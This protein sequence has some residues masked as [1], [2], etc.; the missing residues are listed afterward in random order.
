MPGPAGRVGGFVQNLT[1]S[2]T[3]SAVGLNTQTP[4]G[5]QFTTARSPGSATLNFSG[6]LANGVITGTLTFSE[7]GSGTSDGSNGG[8][9]G[10][11]ITVCGS[12]TIPVT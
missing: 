10:A 1:V 5:G 2:G 3:R 11:P 9:P 8:A 7:S 6:S 4:F 12:V